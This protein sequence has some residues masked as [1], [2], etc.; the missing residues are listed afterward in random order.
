MCRGADRGECRITERA[1]HSRDVAQ[2][3]ALRATLLQLP[4]RLAFEV[5]NDHVPFGHE[6]LA[7]V[8]V[9]V[10]ADARSGSRQVAQI[11]E[12]LE[13]GVA[14]PQNVLRIA[15]IAIVETRQHGFEQLE[16]FVRAFT[17]RVRQLL[18]IP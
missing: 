6:D 15:L 13:Q 7:E 10:T 18:H 14:V 12:L 11:I 5:E 9:P 4:R 1:E 2:R 3:R 8:I 16:M 17:H